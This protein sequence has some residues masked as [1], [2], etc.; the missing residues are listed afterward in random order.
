MSVP[1]VGRRSSMPSQKSYGS[2]PATPSCM[3]S[4]KRAN[5]DDCNGPILVMG[6]GNGKVHGLDTAPSEGIMLP[7]VMEDLGKGDLVRKNV[8]YIFVLWFLHIHVYFF[9]WVTSAD[10]VTHQ[11]VVLS[12]T[13]SRMIVLSSTFRS[14]SYTAPL[15][16]TAFSISPP[17]KWVEI[18]CYYFTTH[19]SPFWLVS[20]RLLDLFAL[21]PISK[22]CIC[23][24]AVTCLRDPF[25][26]A[27]LLMCR[28][29]V[30]KTITS[31]RQVHL[32]GC[33]SLFLLTFIVTHHCILLH[34]IPVVSP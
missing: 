22:L 9:S 23:P 11:K 10:I 3:Q 15:A 33:M 24:V 6:G 16:S 1:Q 30:L 14:F 25:T 17:C 21:T 32:F 5:V 2:H 18:C 13:L 7:P 28:T 31:C 29:F 8:K 26:V 4:S 34:F 19:L 20:G 27:L 12:F